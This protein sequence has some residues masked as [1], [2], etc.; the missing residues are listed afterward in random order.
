MPRYA[1]L[2]AL[3]LA[4]APGAA[5]ADVLQ[6]AQVRIA[7]TDAVTCEVVVSFAVA[8]DRPGN[9]EH[10]LQRLDGSR[11]DLIGVTGASHVAPVRSVG[12]TEAL[13][14]SFPAAGVHRYEVRYRVAQSE[15]WA[16]RCPV[17]LPTVAADG[18]S[19]NVEIEVVLPP[20]AR[21]ASGTFPV[22]RWEG[23]TGR[24]TLANVPAFLRLPYEAPSE[25][26]RPPADLGRLMDIAAV[27]MLIAGT[28]LWIVRRRR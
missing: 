8:L 9:V 2:L 6:Q 15:Q 23:R 19:R 4:A 13:T 7:L 1:L 3:V 24:T 27:G 26:R 11:L 22:L 12:T 18:R 16:Y 17:W 14:L 20:D 5:A 10:R 21:P 28:A 25:T